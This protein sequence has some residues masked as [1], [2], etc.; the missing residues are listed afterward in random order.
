MNV[1]W[2]HGSSPSFTSFETVL[3]TLLRARDS[4]APVVVAR[5]RLGVVAQDGQ[6]AA[7]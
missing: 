3:R 1:V 4:T 6:T 7:S 2:M 5:G